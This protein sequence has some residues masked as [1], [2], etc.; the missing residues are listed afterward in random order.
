M[1]RLSVTITRRVRAMHKD[2]AYS[3]ALRD[4]RLATRVVNIC[5]PALL[6]ALAL[7]AVV[8]GVTTI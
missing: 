6:V 8:Y 1:T 2:T 5:V 3:E 7:L 4:I